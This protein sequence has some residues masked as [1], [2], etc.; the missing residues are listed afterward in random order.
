MKI[1]KSLIVSGGDVNSAFLKKVAY[2][3]EPQYIIGVDKGI[4]VLYK[5]GIVPTYIVGDFDSA[6]ESILGVYQNMQHVQIEYLPAEKDMSDTEYAIGKAE[7]IGST[8][9]LL[10][11]ATGSRIDHM[12]ANIQCLMSPLS[13]GIRAEI[14]DE[15]NRICLLAKGIS[16]KKENLYGK[17]LSFFPLGGVVSGFTLQGVK[18]PLIKHQLRAENSLCVSNEILGDEIKIAFDEGIVVFIQAKD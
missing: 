11:G 13:K 14:L 3:E 4:E 15:N 6:Q 16:I 7:Q 17:Y 9:M 18:Y 5:A 1:V 2:A 10:L 8:Q 12:F